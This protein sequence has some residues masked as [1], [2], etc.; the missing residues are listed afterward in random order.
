MNKIIQ[1]VFRYKKA[2]FKKLIEYGFAEKDGNFSY[3]TNFADGQMSLKITVDNSGEI[4][5]DVT[6]SETEEPFTLFLVEGTEG[7]FIGTVRAEYEKILTDIADKCFEKQVF[8]SRQAKEVIEYIRTRYGGEL[9]FLWEKFSDNAIWRRKDNNKWY[10]VILVVSKRKLG[11]NSDEVSEILDLRMEPDE[12][13][14]TVD[15]QKIFRGYHMNKKHWITLCLDG[16]VKTDEIFSLIDK[17]YD[18]AKRP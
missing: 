11:L 18:L 7:S 4:C 8:K 1:A 13:E 2:N 17:S 14:K 16:S 15:N 6:D 9:E 3:T 5:A 12:L 10:G